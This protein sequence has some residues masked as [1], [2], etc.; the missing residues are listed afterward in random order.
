M[1]WI[2]FVGYCASALV[3]ATFFMR[4]MIPLR[5]LA[6]GSNFAFIAYGFAAGI[7]PVLML[8][9]LLLPLNVYRMIEMLRL[10]RRVESAADGDLSFDWLQPFMK[11]TRHPADRVLFRKGDP[12]D[13]LYVILSGGIR[14]EEIGVR[15]GPGEILGEIGLFAPDRRRTQTAISETEVELLWITEHELAQL[16]YQNPGVAFH[17]LRIITARLLANAAQLEV[18][19]AAN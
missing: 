18:A 9:L 4:T 13:R 12:A 19:R 14:L 5:A 16:C 7:A 11:S 10:I 6:I 3:L 1:S 2:E 8:H 15:L 17:L